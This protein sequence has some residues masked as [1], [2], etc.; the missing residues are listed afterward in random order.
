MITIA[1]YLI[2]NFIAVIVGIPLTLR[3]AH[4]RIP[5]GIEYKLALGAV[6]GMAVSLFAGTYAKSR[7]EKNLKKQLKELYEIP[8]P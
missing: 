6:A 1:N 4:K 7:C 3:N 8:I 5:I 2:I